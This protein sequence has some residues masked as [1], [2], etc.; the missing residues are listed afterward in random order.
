[1][2]FAFSHVDCIGTE[3]GKHH[4]RCG[5]LVFDSTGIRKQI[6]PRQILEKEQNREYV[7]QSLSTFL[8]VF[9]RAS[10]T[11]HLILEDCLD[12]AFR[13][14]TERLIVSCPHYCRI[15]VTIHFS[16]PSI[17][18]QAMFVDFC[19]KLE[20]M[21]EKNLLSISLFGLFKKC[22][23]EEKDF[24]FQYHFRLFHT[25]SPKNDSSDTETLRH[26]SDY[27]FKIPFVWYN[28]GDLEIS[29]INQ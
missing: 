7:K 3:F 14:M 21:I 19:K 22:S 13:E 12:I 27:G 24:L 26:F 18:W 25:C 28:G 10:V 1:M 20:A 9:D 8:E 4:S 23:E 29:D 2:G 6:I 17:S 16:K 15:H 5:L 11:V